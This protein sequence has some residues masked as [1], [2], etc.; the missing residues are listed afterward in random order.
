[1]NILNT[2]FEAIQSVN[3]NVI[4]TLLKRF[5]KLANAQDK[6]GFTPLVFATYFDKIEIAETL[7][8]H[9][10]N[11]NHRDAKGNTA[12]LGVAF[13]DNVDIAKLL[14][15]NNANI[16][17]QNNLGY[18]PLIFATIYNQPKMVG[19]LLNQNA[20]VSLKD[21]EN[22]S[23][24]DYAKEKSLKEIINLLEVKEAIYLQTI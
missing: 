17:A 10:A 12:L 14:L 6:R 19:F 15:K 4:E 22:K 7:I 16:N 9:N 13:K 20:D 24:L 2:F 21:R 18:T 1:M 11:V 23:A 3:I 5:P 8:N